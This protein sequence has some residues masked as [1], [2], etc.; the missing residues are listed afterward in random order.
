MPDDAPQTPKEQLELIEQ[1]VRTELEGRFD[2]IEALG[3]ATLSSSEAEKQ[4]EDLKDRRIKELGKK[5]EF[6]KLKKS[7]G[8]RPTEERANFGQ[9][10]QHAEELLV[11]A[12]D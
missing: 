6:A 1:R 4:L 5:S 10:I 12:F 8:G 2:N 9:A 11:Q 3:G 7:I